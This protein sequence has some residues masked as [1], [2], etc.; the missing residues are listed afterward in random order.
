MQ[1][2]SI[3]FVCLIFAVL[4]GGPLAAPVLRNESRLWRLAHLQNRF[5]A[6]EGSA[7]DDVLTLANQPE[8]LDRVA[9]RVGVNLLL[10]SALPQE[11]WRLSRV[12][13]EQTDPRQLGLD[14]PLG[15]LHLRVLEENGQ[16]AAALD[17]LQ[18]RIDPQQ[19]RSESDLNRM[20]YARA[21][22][23]RDLGLALEE[24]ELAVF[25]AERQALLGTPARLELV[26]LLSAA[27]L[28]R[29]A[30]ER[31][32]CLELV[33]VE[34]EAREL[35]EAEPEFVPAAGA[36]AA[37]PA[38]LSLLYTVRAKLLE[39]LDRADESLAD[40]AHVQSLGG[41]ARQILHG[42]PGDDVLMVLAQFAAALL[43]TRGYVK[44][45]IDTRPSSALVDNLTDFIR[46]G[47]PGQR[48]RSLADFDMAVLAA[49][50][51]YEHLGEHPTLNS[52]AFVDAGSYERELAAAREILATMLSHRA[53]AKAAAGDEVG[54]AGD[55]KQIADLGLDPEKLYY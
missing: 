42:I 51:F 43:D 33:N 8:G 34:I 5:A 26:S 16:F 35:G 40:R 17:W 36:A 23:N 52:T 6:G 31:S 18:A 28:A 39:R 13:V 45:R 10:D 27:L 7:L 32:Q 46:F 53:E 50:T 22:A 25:G 30:E 38:E 12:L 24:I 1:R 29:N 11:A 19:P 44:Y 2:L 49:R 47:V 48:V 41:D 3:W 21:L 20:A 55:R 15:Q 54:A 37:P 14:Q 4:L 9:A